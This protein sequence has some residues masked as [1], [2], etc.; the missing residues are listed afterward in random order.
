MENNVPTD[1]CLIVLPTVVLAG[2]YEMTRMN[3]DLT[4]QESAYPNQIQI[5]NNLYMC[6]LMF[7]SMCFC[8]RDLRVRSKSGSL[9]PEV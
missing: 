4:H 8:I 2:Y 9:F 5:L 1:F 3:K 7:R 6:Y